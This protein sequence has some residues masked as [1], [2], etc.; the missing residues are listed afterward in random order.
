V[1]DG[2]NHPSNLFD[3]A[4]V[5]TGKWANRAY[6]IKTHAGNRGLDISGGKA[7]EGKAVIQYDIH[8]NDN[9]LWQ[10]VPVETIEP[11]VEA[12]FVIAPNTLYQ[13]VSVLD[14]TKA[15]SVDQTGKVVVRTYNGDGNQKFSLETAHN[16]FAFIASHNRSRVC[17]FQDGQNKGAEIVV[18]QQPHGSSWF[19][20]T[21][22]TAGKWANK[23]YIIKTHVGKQ[24]LDIA[25][26]QAT[27]GQKVL[28]YDLHGGDNQNWLIEPVEI[29]DPEVPANFAPF[30]NTSY[31]I[32][33]VLDKSK[34]LSADQ[35]NKIVVR[36]FNN[37][38]SQKFHI[39]L[40][41]H[42]YA[43]TATHNNANI[44]VQD[45]TKNNAAEIAVV[46][47]KHHSN[48]FEISVV[49]TGK[50]ANRAY[51][52][53]TH[54]GNR[55]LDIAGGQATEGQ[56]VLQ[57]DLHGNENQIWQIVAT[58]Q[59]GGFGFHWGSHFPQ[60]ASFRR[61]H[62]QSHGH[63]HGHGHSGHN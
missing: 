12:N 39:F 11:D 62:G 37:E 10:I 13:V 46:P 15:L 1:T 33:S 50:W 24:G 21:R 57:Y 54:A 18:D 26:G 45:D 36:T 9:Q 22:A 17:V 16:K 20:V 44:C 40:E 7:E 48:W 43:F 2:G 63:G 25:G 38:P 23:A 3:F 6:L 27:E 19:E 34:A 4:R 59:Q 51:I 8:G 5:S 42:K 60:H 41:H 52:I 14:K 35:G 29:V 47:G 58:D 31:K 53:K 61:H 28:Q 55:A 30:A 32:V 49:T 56:K